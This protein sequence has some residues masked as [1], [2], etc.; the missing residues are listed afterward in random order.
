[1][2]K[3]DPDTI[4]EYSDLFLRA[5]PLIHELRSGIGVLMHI[6]SSQH[7]IEQDEIAYLAD[8]LH[9]AVERLQAVWENEEKRRKPPDAEQ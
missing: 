4:T 8:K 6:S 1:M 5:E 7:E 3:A 9:E 2:P